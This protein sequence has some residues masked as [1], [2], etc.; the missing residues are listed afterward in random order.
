LFTNWKELTHLRPA[1]T[2]AFSNGGWNLDA[3]PEL[4]PLDAG[5]TIT[6]ADIEGPGVITTIHCTQHSVNVLG[7]PPDEVRALSARGVILEIWFDRGE[8]PAVRCPL[9]DFFADGCCGRAAHFTTPFVE[10]APESYNCFLP[11]PFGERA[12]V[13]LRN[14]TPHNFANYSYVEVQ[15]LPAW[16][17]HLGYLHA[18]WNREAF[19]LTRDTRRCLFQADA[20]GHLVGRAWSIATDEPLFHAFAFIMEGNNEV[21]ADGAERPVADYLGTEDSFGFSWG[22]PKVFCGLRNGA[23]FI[24]NEGPTL[25]ST[26]RFRDLS[27]IPFDHGLT[28]HVNWRHEFRDHAEFQE[29]LAGRIAADGAWVDYATVFYWY[30]ETPGHPHAPLPPLGD[31]VRTVL[32]PSR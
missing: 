26:Y 5:S 30:Q 11:M 27:V 18:T 19:Q 2:F 9:G 15:R 25:L 28:W 23:N 8:E 3:Y 24:Q 31:R 17:H 6:V 21:H 4:E 12:R 10:K 7:I 1:H 16:D 22:W 20:S 13:L 14:E 32:H 29:K